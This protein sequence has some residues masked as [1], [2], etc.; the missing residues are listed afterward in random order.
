[1]Q[2]HHKKQNNMTQSNTNTTATYNA[3]TNNMNDIETPCV[4]VNATNPTKPVVESS[5]TIIKESTTHSSTTRYYLKVFLLALLVKTFV[6][7]LIL[8]IGREYEQAQV[9]KSAGTRGLYETN[10]VCTMRTHT[11]DNTLSFE[12]AVVYPNSIGAANHQGEGIV[13]HCGDCGQCSNP[14]DIAYY[15]ESSQSLYEDTLQCSKRAV[16]GRRVV[17]KCMRENVGLTEGCNDCWVSNIMCTVQKC[18][19]SC[20]AYALLNG[21]IRSGGSAEE[22]NECTKCDEVRC[23]PA[24]LECAGANRRR[25]GIHSD[26]IRDE[27]EVCHSVTPEWWKDELLQHQWK[28]QTAEL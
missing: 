12:T 25:S 4:P 8:L 6:F 16:L 1:V 23:G 28:Q 22:L 27:A 11:S 21:G 18:I 15:D 2:E 7:I 14:V 10:N 13:A 26:I 19:F 17:E 5:S 3:S 9:R 24:F 20:T